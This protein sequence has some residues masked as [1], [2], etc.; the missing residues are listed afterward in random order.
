MFC[1]IAF[2]LMKMLNM[3]FN[4]MPRLNIFMVSLY[5]LHIAF[6]GKHIVYVCIV[7]LWKLPLIV[8]YCP[9]IG[10]KM[11]EMCSTRNLPKKSSWQPHRLEWCGNGGGAVT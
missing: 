11:K 9:S 2:L 7:L 5:V 1:N 4:V 6:L 3:M 8:M 10:E